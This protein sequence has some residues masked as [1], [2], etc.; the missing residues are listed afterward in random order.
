VLVLNWAGVDY[1]PYIENVVPVG[2]IECDPDSIISYITEK[3]R[4]FGYKTESATIMAPL[5][6]TIIHEWKKILRLKDGRLLFNELKRR[7]KEKI[8][9]NKQYDSLKDYEKPAISR[10][11]PVFPWS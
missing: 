11:A 7:I 9:G 5:E 2:N 10:R 4:N 6:D 8:R 1:E 3:T